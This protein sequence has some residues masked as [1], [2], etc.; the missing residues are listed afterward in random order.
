MAPE[1]LTL[2]SRDGTRLHATRTRAGTA[3]GGVVFQH[4]Y[5]DH[6]GR[7]QHVFDAL[8]AAG[9]DVIAPD[10][11]GHGRSA[12]QRG[13]LGHFGE[14]MDDLEAGLDAIRAAGHTRPFLLAHS[15]GALL[16]LRLMTDAE[17]APRD[18][19][20]LVV[21]SPFLGLNPDVSPT[22]AVTPV[23]PPSTP[24]ADLPRPHALDH[25]HAITRGLA[26]LGH[27]ARRMPLTLAVIILVIVATL[28]VSLLLR[29]PDTRPR[30]GGIS[31]LGAPVSPRAPAPRPA[32]PS[33]A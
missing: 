1:A 26:N 6:A 23:P 28:T 18:L 16:A 25:I 7:Y 11:R 2:T 9:F 15:M 32:A 5:A 30:G 4:G 10:L 14:Y 27:G 3:R 21:T 31:S 17:R 22:T 19:A 12:G 33:R 20:G 8:A 13:K 24:P 29:R